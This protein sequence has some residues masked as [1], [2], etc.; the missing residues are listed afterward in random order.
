MKAMFGAND[1]SILF[2]SD[3]AH[4]HL[5]GI[6]NQQSCCYW[7]LENP[8]ELHAKPLHNSKVMVRCGVGKSAIIGPFFNDNNG[9]AVTMNSERYTEMIKNFLCLNY[10]EN[11]CLS[12]VCGFSGMERRST[13]P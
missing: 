1:N 11:V 4:F 3:E 9:N 12:D 13:Q 8:R 5:S 10:D 7:A 2:K 6:V